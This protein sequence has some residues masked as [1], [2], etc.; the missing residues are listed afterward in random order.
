MGSNGFRNLPRD[1]KF[2]E[3]QRRL[4]GP[5]GAFNT[6]ARDGVFELRADDYD[7]DIKWRREKNEGRY[8]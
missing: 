6:H 4:S 7:Q 5:N 1:T 3:N 2:W 8:H